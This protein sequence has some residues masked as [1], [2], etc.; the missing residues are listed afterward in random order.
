MKIADLGWHCSSIRYFYAENV[1]HIHKRK[2]HNY[3]LHKRY[4]MLLWSFQIILRKSMKSKL[5]YICIIKLTL[6][7]LINGVLFFIKIY[8]DIFH[9][10][11]VKYTNVTQSSRLH[12]YQTVLF[13]TMFRL[14][15]N[16]RLKLH[17][18]FGVSY[19][20]H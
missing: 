8:W 16:R 5:I 3:V 4:D 1:R 17:H 9:I 15:Q 19:W 13:S 10:G 2:L 18:T 14:Q 12:L 11:I 20:Y 6:C 7:K